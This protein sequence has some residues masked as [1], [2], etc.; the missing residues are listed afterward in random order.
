MKIKC[1]TLLAAFTVFVVGAAMVLRAEQN[2]KQAH[3]KKN[4]P[5]E[6]CI[7]A[8]V[9][10]LCSTM[11]HDVAT[12]L[13]LGYS[14]L[15]DNEVPFDVFSWQSFI[16]MNWPADQNGNPSA[17]SILHDST[18]PRV[19][20]YFKTPFDV[21]PRLA[22]MK[23]SV[24]RACR[25]IEGYEK[26]RPF[27]ITAKGSLLQ[28]GDFLEAF[29]DVP[30]ID[31]NLN[32]VLYD[33]AMNDVEADYITDNQLDTIAGQQQF[34]GDIVFLLG[35]YADPVAKTG[36]KVG[37]IEIK[38]AWRIITDDEDA[39]RYFTLEAIISI[40]ADHTESGESLCFPA[41][42]GLVGF[43]LVHAVRGPEHSFQR[44][45]IW[46]TFEHVDNAP[47]ATNARDQTDLSLPLPAQAIAP[48]SVSKEYAFF[49]PAYKGVPNSPPSKLP[50]QQVFRWAAKA[51]YAMSYANDG[52]YG[53][54]VVQCWK[55]FA[56]TAKVN[57]YFQAKL[58][59]TVWANYQLI[60]SQWMGGTEGQGPPVNGN[61]PRFLSNTTL[62]TYLQFDTSLG[63]C[64]Q[65]HQ[66]AL[67]RTGK[68]ANFS[69][70]LMH[71]K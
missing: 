36:G 29:T 56:P 57:D 33:I 34:P 37:S 13:G 46:S 43:H 58:K 51:P 21:F 12:E 40:D 3:A 32:F 25:S 18:S 48:D 19:W 26:R 65:C 22:A 69:F 47:L 27:L 5:I 30:L 67:T 17:K 61:I 71:A 7:N 54:Q 23:A 6:A 10:Q 63:S 16:A 62:E 70:L 66:M 59:G 4:A 45:W 28:P 35:Y 64:L 8:P 49:N 53:T 14:S 68:L 31:R 55:V 39:G 20:Q 2:A 50:G 60:G 38:S 42:L 9:D 52:K 44:D 24:T 41:K 11:P 15:N 1:S